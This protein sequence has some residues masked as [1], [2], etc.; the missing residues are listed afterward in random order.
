MDDY[1]VRLLADQME[2]DSE[3]HLDDPL[4]YHLVDQWA[5]LLAVQMVCETDECWARQ[6]GVRMDNSMDDDLD[7]ATGV[8]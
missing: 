8:P 2:D 7:S 5:V 6:L 1:W 3:L 4:A